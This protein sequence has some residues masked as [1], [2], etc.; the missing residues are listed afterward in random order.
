MF[1]PEFFPTPD[2]VIRRML[3]PYWTGDRVAD[4]RAG[5]PVVRAVLEPS[6]GK[7]NILDWMR[8]TAGYEP[9]M[10]RCRDDLPK[11]YAI[12]Q[13]PELVAI[14][15]AK[16]YR[17]LSR[18]F[19]NFKLENRVDLIVM[20]PPFSTGAKHLLH[21]WQILEEGNIVC[22]LNAETVRNPFSSERE[23]LAKVIRDHGSIE[24]IG[25]VFRD[26]ERA[27]DV[28][29]A[30]VHLH[31][32]RETKSELDFEFS[33]PDNDEKPNTPDFSIG[34]A[35]ETGL[36]KPDRIGALIRQ[37]TCARDAYVRFLRARSEI[38]F[39]T[40]GVLS[41]HDLVSVVNNSSSGRYDWEN[42]EDALESF[43][44]T[45]RLKFWEHILRS[46][47]VEKYLTSA[48][49]DKFAKFIEQNGSMALTAENINNIL[50]MILLNANSILAQ[51]VVDVFD[52]FTKYHKVNRCHPEGWKTN[53]SW[54]VNRKVILPN[55]VRYEFG[56][57]RSCYNS[58]RTYSD[59]D[60]AM[61]FLS[62]KAFEDI[63]TIEQA[64]E[65][66]WKAD[67]NAGSM[68]STF[69]D[70]R[71]FKKGTIHLMFRDE[72]LWERFNIQ[73]VEGRNWV[74]DQAA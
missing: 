42:N 17:V 5:K 51:S 65:T 53:S 27:S 14:L 25:Q 63:V 35:D 60:K 56:S 54:K 66:A 45:T 22:L 33:Y 2:H 1:D 34:Q 47:G 15:Q 36:M 58:Y 40:R 16:E 21:A 52:T 7:G 44:D 26:A 46:V 67:R 43:Q 13:N 64:M 6:A 41:P 9:G 12:E 18:N 4:H 38:E 20:N 59:V 71:C 73:A 3:L 70:I 50:G 30:I 72:K 8:R 61:C 37:Y 19:L 57:F 69:F 11:L 32:E 55:W 29:V 10:R 48:L 24:Y 23:L 39:F 74:G 49:R 68:Q 28:E 62:G 31:K